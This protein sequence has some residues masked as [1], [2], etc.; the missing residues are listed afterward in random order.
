MKTKNNTKTLALLIEEQYGKK[1][2]SKRDKFDKGYESFKLGAMI[3][4]ARLEKGLTQEQLA[5]K[6]GTNKAYISK[7]ENDIK[8][9]RISTLQ[10]IIEVGLG[11]HLNLSVTL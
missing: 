11:G 1:G 3:Q 5:E 6:C 10:K 9:V 8:D 2:T 4:E 7:V